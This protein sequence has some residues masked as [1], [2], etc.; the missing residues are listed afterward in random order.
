MLKTFRATIMPSGAIVFDEPVNLTRTTVVL[1]TFLDEQG[2][3]P[4]TTACEPVAGVAPDFSAGQPTH[5]EKPA[6]PSADQ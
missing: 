4:A 3:P 1:V 6:V 5:F 2:T